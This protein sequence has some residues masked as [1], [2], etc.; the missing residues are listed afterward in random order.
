MK[1]SQIERVM[2]LVR[3][4]GDRCVVMD[5]ASDDVLV[6]M[7][8][9]DYEKLL[10]GDSDKK[11][12]AGMS[13]RD[14]MD[15]VDREIAYWRSLHAEE[16]EPEEV[17]YNDFAFTAEEEGE[18]REEKIIDEI[19]EDNFSEEDFLDDE[20]PDEAEEEKVKKNNENF[21]QNSVE[22]VDF[23]DDK[24]FFS[25]HAVLKTEETLDDLPHEDED[26]FLLEPV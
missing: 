20:I 25:N 26:T 6:M 19:P 11:N 17:R 3:R 14:M 21:E 5:G 1:S 7:Q 22:D 24:D 9:N 23:D 2:N 15:K 12:L 4:T 16:T 10:D 13:E 18:K 8:L